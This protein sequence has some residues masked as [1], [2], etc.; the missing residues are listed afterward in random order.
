MTL[1][2]PRAGQYMTVL[3]FLSGISG[4]IYQVV[5]FRRLALIFGVTSYALGIV[6]A[7]FMSGLAIG[8]VLGGWLGNQKRNP[9]RMYGATEI[10]IALLSVAVLP[11]INVVQAIYVALA[12]HLV[13]HKPAL[14]AVRFVLSFAVLVPATACMGATLPLGV[15]AL[16]SQSSI[17]LG[18]LYA[19]NTLGAVSGV[20][21]G[22]FVLLGVFG[23]TRSAL[24]AAGLNLTCGIVALF[25]L[26]AEQTEPEETGGRTGAFSSFQQRVLLSMALGGFAA[27]G[28]EIVWTRL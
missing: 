20:L 24:M 3:F 17:A 2:R 16:D 23:L 11:A 25:F 14:S 13:Q 12:P 10:G 15:R 4:L 27:L 26:R 19:A 6:L 5:W 9:L 1:S 21:I 7:A 18:R 28:Y 22:G 8:A